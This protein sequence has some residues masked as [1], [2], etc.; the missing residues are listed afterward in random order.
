MDAD[1]AGRRRPPPTR[2]VDRCVPA[3]ASSTPWAPLRATARSGGPRWT[4]DARA[5]LVGA[6]ADQVGLIQDETVRRNGAATPSRPLERRS[7]C[8][9]KPLLR[10]HGHRRAQRRRPVRCLSVRGRRCR[11]ARP[12]RRC[13]EPTLS[14]GR[15]AQRWC[16]AG[17]AGQA[18]RPTPSPRAARPAAVGRGGGPRSRGDRLRAP[19]L[20]GCDRGSS[21]LTA[22]RR[23]QGRSPPSSSPTH[24]TGRAAQPEG[25]STSAAHRSSGGH[26]RTSDQAEPRSARALRTEVGL[27]ASLRVMDRARRTPATHQLRQSGGRTGDRQGQVPRRRR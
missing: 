9:R 8:G 12:A 18:S 24:A 11:P 23:R 7:A 20:A 25:R 5:V 17:A 15:R 4:H 13:Y 26:G 6:G 19:G 3:P 14:S 10:Q 22:G 27:R 2:R 21:G 16:S 1:R